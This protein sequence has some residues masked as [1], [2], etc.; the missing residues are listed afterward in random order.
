MALKNYTASADT[1]IVNVFQPDLA[2]R[3]TGA[4]MGAADVV[5]VFSIYGRVTTSSQEL[6]RALIKFPIT[7]IITDRAADTIPA[8]GSVSFYLRMFNA[9]HSKTVPQD[10]TLSVLSVSQSWQEGVGLDLERYK[11]VTKGN[12]G[13]NWMSG[14][15]TAESAATATVKFNSSTVSDYDDKTVTV[16]STDRTTVVYTLDDDTNSN[17]YGDST[18][19]IGIQGVSGAPSKI[20]ELFT[21]AVNHSSNAHADKITA[22]E[23]ASA[24]VTLTQDV[25]GQPGNSAVATSDSTNIIVSGFTGGASSYWTDINGT[26]LAGGSYHTGGIVAGTVGT[27]IH[28]FTQTFST[29]LEDLEINITPLVEQWID[30]TYPNYGVGIKLSASYEASESGSADTVTSRTPGELALD[31]SDDTQSVIYNPSGS[32]KSYYTKRFFA[33]GTQYFFKR[34]TIQAR[35]DSTVKDSRGDVYFS[36]SL[37]PPA[38][39]MNTLYFYNYIRGKLTNIPSLGTDNRVYASIFSGSANNS[40]PSGSALVLSPDN[41]GYVRSAEP[42]VITGGLV[43]TGIYSASFALTGTTSITT[44]YDVWFT[45]S[46][47]MIATSSTTQYFTGSFFP[48]VVN[49]AQTVSKPAYYLNVTNL[50][51]KYRADETAR[52]NLYI[53]NKNWSPT[54]YTVANSTSDST[55]IVSAS[56]R[57]FRTMDAYGAVP[58]GT[59]SDLHTHMS[60][61][62]S[63]NYFDFDMNLLE[64]G[65]EYAFKFAFY[66]SALNSWSEQPGAFKFRVEDYEY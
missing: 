15:N 19:N 47:T 13:A 16:T 10:Y 43:T 50:R 25:S 11:D 59:G 7:K 24:T 14:S 34:P 66:D 60:Y 42:T 62:V 31:A 22:V 6:S 18:T 63:G 9:E 57:V 49:P 38:D 65:Y 56:Y 1:T 58:Y 39:N 44:L 51:G 17:T 61:D 20:A 21:T 46:D 30:S 53:R 40:A 12:T 37:A 52:F 36:S 27:E 29:G 54:I 32:T 3:G 26:L 35:W 4:N 41:S 5:E 48:Q 33:R 28:T 45:G 55:T 8:S 23:G 64:P 2:T